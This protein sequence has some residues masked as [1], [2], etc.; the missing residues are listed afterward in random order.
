MSLVMLFLDFEN[1]TFA[2]YGPCIFHQGVVQS[3]SCWKSITYYYLQS[4]VLCSQRRGPT[5]PENEISFVFSRYLSYC[6]SEPTSCISLIK[7]PLDLCR[8][9]FFWQG[10]LY[11]CLNLV[12]SMQKRICENWQKVTLRFTIKYF[13]YLTLFPPKLCPQRLLQRRLS[14]FLIFILMICMGNEA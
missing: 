8:S 9:F 7:T 6:S 13:W 3:F 1:Q 2:K 5:S 11:V 12:S 14:N 4:A 10:I